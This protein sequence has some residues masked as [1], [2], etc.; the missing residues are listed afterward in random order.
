MFCVIQNFINAKFLNNNCEIINLI[1][2]KIKKLN[3]LF[4]IFD[5]ELKKIIFWRLW[6]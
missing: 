4:L 2:Q 5:D 6:K 1:N 3:Y